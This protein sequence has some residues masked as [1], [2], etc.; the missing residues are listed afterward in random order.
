[1]GAGAK[2]THSTVGPVCRIGGEVEESI[3]HGYS[4][5]AH[6]GFLGHSY[7]GEW[8]NFAAGTQTSDLRTD[9][10]PVVMLSDG[11]KIDTGLTKVGAFLG[12]HTKTGIN[13]LLNTGSVAGVFCN[14]YQ[15][16]LLPPRDIP[17]FCNFARGELVQGAELT[18][19]LSAAAAAMGRRG[20][21]LTAAHTA[22]YQRLWEQTAGRR[23]RALRA[24]QRR[25][26]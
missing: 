17:S 11:T 13:A 16:N 21:E 10:K 6:D 26:G 14:I 1:V 7:V 22:L 18:A 9:Y 2:V 24:G 25:G 8:V 23:E 12:D 20:Q 4:N 19:Q 3:V 5:K 15:S